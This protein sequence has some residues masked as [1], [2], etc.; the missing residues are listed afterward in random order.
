VDWETG[1]ERKAVEG[2]TA[3]REFR[4]GYKA[5]GEKEQEGP[6]QT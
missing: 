5:T 1:G 4:E 3:R 2:R 6:G